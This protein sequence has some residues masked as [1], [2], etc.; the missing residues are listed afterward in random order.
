MISHTERLKEFD[1]TNNI[2]RWCGAELTEDIGFQEFH[3]LKVHGLV[4]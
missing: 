3:M 2:C 1:T 4:V